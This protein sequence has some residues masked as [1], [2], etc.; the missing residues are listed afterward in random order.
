MPI[1]AADLLLSRDQT[2][3]TPGDHDSTDTIDFGPGVSNLDAK[4]PLTAVVLVRETVASDAPATVRFRLVSADDAA[5]ADPAT[6]WDSG[7]IDGQALKL[8]YRLVGEVAD[9]AQ[10]KRY[11]KL[12][13]T[14]A[15][16]PLLAGKFMAWVGESDAVEDVRMHGAPS[17][18]MG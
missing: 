14:V 2:V 17:F 18:P 3:A 9:R 13:Y 8:G 7:A 11:A 1:D 12:I 15:G 5:F 4:K 16:A 6:L 10:V